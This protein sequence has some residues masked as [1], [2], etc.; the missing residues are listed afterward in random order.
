MVP[1]CAFILRVRRCLAFLADE[2]GSFARERRKSR[3]NRVVGGFLYFGSLLPNLACR[4][5]CTDSRGLRPCL[6]SPQ[7]PKVQG[8]NLP[9]K[10]HKS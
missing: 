9:V 6:G 2:Q 3:A 4:G 7:K 10:P 1:V 8:M 5:V